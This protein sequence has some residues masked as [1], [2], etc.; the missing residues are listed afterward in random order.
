MQP[1]AQVNVESLHTFEFFTF[2]GLT[3]VDEVYG[4]QSGQ[5]KAV[6]YGW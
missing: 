2:L 4:P 3:D 5:Q 6:L 1:L